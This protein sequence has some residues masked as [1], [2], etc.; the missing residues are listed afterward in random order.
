[1]TLRLA[2]LTSTLVL[3]AAAPAAAEPVEVTAQA[4]AARAEFLLTAT[5]PGPAAIICLVDSGVNDTLDTTSVVARVALAGASH[6][7]SPT[8]HGTQMAS[9]IGAAPNGYGM[10]GLWPTARIVSVAASASG[11]D[12]FTQP[13]YIHGMK[14]CDEVSNV[15]DVKVIVLP[16]SS[17]LP[18]DDE[19][20]QALRDEIEAAR[21]DDVNI[22]AAAGNSQ[23]RPVALPASQPGILS[24][25]ATDSATG[26]LCGF[27]ATGASLLAPGCRLDGSEPA[28]GAPL[29]TQQGTSFAAV[30]VAAALA[31]LRTWRP[32]LS[33]E[34][35]QRVLIDNA[36]TASSGRALDVTAAFVAAGMGSLVPAVPTPTSTPTP[37]VPPPPTPATKTRLPKPHLRVGL[38]KR[39]SRHYLVVR[40]TN[41]PRGMRLT[42]RV[43]R[44]GRRGKLQRIAL[45]SDATGVIRV[46]VRSWAR[47]TAR[48]SDPARKR[49]TSVPT[50]VNARR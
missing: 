35:A 14:R 25:G 46:R 50:I 12:S 26:D 22:V 27:S 31:A 23:G 33:A 10:V 36:L 39:G 19:G 17:E 47:V 49:L 32:D 15:Y 5:P 21:V 48:F 44:K 28:S 43:Y 38:R 30:I 16:F 42:V 18:L 20:T 4:K 2:V 6:D 37:T 24:V 8:L 45:R 7:R 29:T 34:A 13:G 11:Q 41:R 40:A 3:I 9:F 1:M